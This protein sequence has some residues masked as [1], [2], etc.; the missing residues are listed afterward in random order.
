PQQHAAKSGKFEVHRWRM[1]GKFKSKRA[2]FLR[3]PPA[4]RARN[5]RLEE[6][7]S[8]QMRRAR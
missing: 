3:R 5:A 2:S 6:A 4:E 7:L 1:F 8:L